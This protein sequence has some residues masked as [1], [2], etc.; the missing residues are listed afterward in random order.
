MYS[1]RK[2]FY[3]LMTDKI[4]GPLVGPIKF[5]L[6]VCSLIY[7][8]VVKVLSTGYEKNFFISYKADPKVISI[9]NITLGGTGKT[10]ATISIARILESFGKRV[11]ILI[12]GY[13]ADEYKMLEEEL[14]DVPILIGPDRVENSKRAFYDFGADTVILDDGFQHYR[15]HKDLDILLLDASNP[16]GNHE[17]VPRG[18]LREPVTALRRADVIVL[19]KVDSKSARLNEANTAINRFAKP[20]PVLEAVY[21]PLNI[22][23]LDSGKSVGLECVNK[24]RVCLVSSIGNPFYFKENI[25][26]LGAEVELEFAFLDHYDYKRSDF[27]G[28]GKEARFLGVDFIIVTKKDAVKL[29]RLALSGE[30]D[31]PILVLEVDFSIMKNE[32]F[33]YDR[34]SGLYSD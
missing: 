3:S 10:Q 20:N 8:A 15:I 16:F 2:F 12:R 27:V 21:K 31:I 29:K 25:M 24:K 33:L 4:T 28:I 6:W 22:Y 32:T 7:G 17:L 18:I 13:G 5:V 19:T 14:G 26:R 1:I 34:L 9:G 11:A 30:L 23:E